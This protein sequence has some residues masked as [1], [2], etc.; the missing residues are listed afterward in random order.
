MFFL[1]FKTKETIDY[2]KSF[3]EAIIWLHKTDVQETSA[4]TKQSLPRY[5]EAYY[6]VQHIQCL[7]NAT[8]DLIRMHLSVLDK[9][10][11]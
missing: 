2:K 4:E 1:D 6:W 10:Y 8:G 11:V 7:K 9:I 3:C 5:F